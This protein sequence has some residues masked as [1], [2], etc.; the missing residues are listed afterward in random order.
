MN[1]FTDAAG[2]RFSGA[3]RQIMRFPAGDL[4]T[5]KA[6]WSVTMYGLDKQFSSQPD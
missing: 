2:E 6:F 3:D 5:V 4:P 1:T